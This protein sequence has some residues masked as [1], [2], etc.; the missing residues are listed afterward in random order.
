MNK[1]TTY[2]L[3]EEAAV[4]GKKHVTYVFAKEDG[5]KSTE[6]GG[7]LE[8]LADNV[9]ARQSQDLGIQPGD[10]LTTLPASRI[11]MRRERT[12]AI[13]RPVAD[14]LLVHFDK[15]LHERISAFRR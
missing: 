8:T 10:I 14:E 15:L 4:V 9:A 11:T 12:I 6:A 1:P 3:Y 5:S 7:Y 2:Y 13:Q